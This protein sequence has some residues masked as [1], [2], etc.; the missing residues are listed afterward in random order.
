[1]KQRV[2]VMNGSRIIETQTDQGEWS[3][4]KVEKAGG[5]KAG[6]Y[7]LPTDKKA[8]KEGDFVGPVVHVDER[9][10]YQ[11]TGSGM[12]CHEKT[13]FT[14]LPPVGG[15]YCIEYGNGGMAKFHEQIQQARSLSR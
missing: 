1:M 14:R 10:V 7:N 15:A 5:L 11:K 8:M 9:F 4:V 13:A 2:V 6:I 3:V 12:V